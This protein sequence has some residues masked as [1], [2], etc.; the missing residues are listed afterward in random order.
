MPPPHQYEGPI[1]K[2]KSIL[3]GISLLKTSVMK[4]SSTPVAVHACRANCI[5]IADDNRLDEKPTLYELCGHGI[6]YQLGVLAP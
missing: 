4:L 1:G 3:G 5:P 2:K 6:R